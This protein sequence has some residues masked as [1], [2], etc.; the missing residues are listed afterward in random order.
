MNVREQ[1]KLLD[2][3]MCRLN[4]LYAE[5]AKNNGISYNRMMTLYALNHSKECT[6]K[7]ICE[8]WMLPKQTINT[9]IKDFEKK[10]YITFIKGSKNSKIIKLTALGEEYAN[11]KLDKL[12]KLENLA[13][14]KLG[15]EKWSLLLQYTIDYEKTFR[16]VVKNE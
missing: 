1:I 12:Y 5:W 11:S 9:I 16:E 4:A 2:T 6:Q 15:M 3:A 8:G 13:T 7:E 14:E 10:G